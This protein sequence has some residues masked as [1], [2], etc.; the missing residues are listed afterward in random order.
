M[1]NS[2]DLEI[3]DDPPRRSPSYPVLL[4]AAGYVWI[5]FGLLI[6]ATAV[7]L[8]AV[9]GAVQ[10]GVPGAGCMPVFSL[11]VG[12]VFLHVGRQSINGAA[13]DTLGN[14]IGSMIIGLL[15]LGSGFTYYRAGENLAAACQAFA[16][17]GLV[18]AGTLAVVA[19]HDYLEWRRSNKKKRKSNDDE[20]HRD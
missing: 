7:F 2:D 18:V 20:K 15:Q 9:V 14:G 4:T 5:G 12:I 16:C 17:A 19:R 8:F 11:V 13:K 10:G 1:R 3:D 6:L